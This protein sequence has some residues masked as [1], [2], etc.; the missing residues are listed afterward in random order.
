MGGIYAAQ[1]SSDLGIIA[2]E[3]SSFGE[4]VVTGSASSWTIFGTLDVGMSGFGTL[5][6][7]D[8]TTVTNEVFATLG[9]FL[10]G[11]IMPTEGGVG[12]VI[13]AGSGSTW[14]VNGDLYLGLFAW[15]RWTLSA[16]G[17]VIIDGDLIGG[18]W[19]P[20]S[21][22]PQ[23]IIELAGSDDYETPAIDVFGLADGFDP[24][25]DL[26]DGFVP[27]AGDT[28]MIAHADLEL[29]P[30]AFDLPKLPPPRVWE[31]IQDANSV[32]L[33]V[34]PVIPGDI[35]GDGSVGANDLLILLANWGPCGDCDDCP[36][37]LN[38]DCTVG[39]EDLFVLLANWG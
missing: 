26:V 33:H 17:K 22:Q 28:F 13:V 21:D 15:G 24:R 38:G 14:T 30:F 6:I 11:D 9:T 27:K 8:A 1:V 18:E 31:V 25:V 35:D 16:G 3:L 12:E 36:A 20:D 5:I 23:T 10:K 34:G 19:L 32:A 39:A 37:D 29:M 7:Q 4:V 2:Q